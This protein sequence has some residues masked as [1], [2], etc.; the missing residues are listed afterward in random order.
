MLEVDDGHAIH[1]GR[2]G[3]PGGKPAAFLLCGPGSGCSAKQRQQFNPALPDV[4]LLDQRGCGRST[5]F[6]GKA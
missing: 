5:P 1:R 4:L 6:A 2:C 3:T